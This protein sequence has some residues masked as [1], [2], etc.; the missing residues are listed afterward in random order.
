MNAVF[1]I[2]LIVIFVIVAIFV[3]DICKDDAINVLEQEHVITVLKE[4]DYEPQGD[5][6][7]VDVLTEE[8]TKEKYQISS[9]V[10]KDKW[11]PEERL[12]QLEVNHTYYVETYGVRNS[13]IGSYK[14]IINLREL[15]GTQEIQKLS[16]SIRTE[17]KTER[18]NRENM[19]ERTKN[20]SNANK[21][22]L[23]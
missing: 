7:L 15:S 14:N 23:Y 9:S 10:M 1:T 12:Y 4:P 20:V 2:T 8:D 19:V 6:Y 11:K 22:G 21:G 16:E 17:Q 3:T 5:G 18:I 13:G